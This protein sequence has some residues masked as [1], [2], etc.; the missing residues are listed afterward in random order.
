MYV[1][2]C[3]CQQQFDSTLMHVQ[4]HI[5]VHLSFYLIMFIKIMERKYVCK[6]GKGSK[7]LNIS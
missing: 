2:M 7:L 6:L 1:A 3:M 4:L 5:S